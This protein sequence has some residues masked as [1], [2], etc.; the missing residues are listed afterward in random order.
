MSGT[1]CASEKMASDQVSDSSPGALAMNVSIQYRACPRRS[2][3][4]FSLRIGY[5]ELSFRLGDDGHVAA[6]SPTSSAG[7]L[8]M[9]V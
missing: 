3:S 5:S 2:V 4:S 9:T 8:A 7:P 1:V 6:R